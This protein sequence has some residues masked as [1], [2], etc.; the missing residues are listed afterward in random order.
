MFDE[1]C[2]WP[3]HSV[4]HRTPQGEVWGIQGVVEAFKR[5]C[6]LVSLRDVQRHGFRNELGIGG[7]HGTNH[8]RKRF[9]RGCDRTEEVEATGSLLDDMRA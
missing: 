4:Q 9:K 6:G 5:G 7:H 2:M 3:L 8:G 1:A